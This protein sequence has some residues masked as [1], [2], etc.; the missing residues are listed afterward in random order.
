MRGEIEKRGYQGGKVYALNS[1]GWEF[2]T[3]RETQAQ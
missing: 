2:K 3:V 1:D